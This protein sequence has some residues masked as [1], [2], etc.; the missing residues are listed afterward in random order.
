[1]YSTPRFQNLSSKKKLTFPS[2]TLQYSS[3]P[4]Q[5]ADNILPR[6]N[7]ESSTLPV[8]VVVWLRLY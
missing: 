8:A 6:A 3:W 4:I 1:M 5:L 2:V 7:F